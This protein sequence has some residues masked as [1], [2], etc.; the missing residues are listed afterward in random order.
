MSVRYLLTDISAW[1]RS[2]MNNSAPCRT[3]GCDYGMHRHYHDR[4]YCGKCG[5]NVCPAYRQPRHAW[6]GRVIFIII[7][8]LFVLLWKVAK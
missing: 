4:T 6:V 8:A 7:V 5:R 3:C 2:F 1:F